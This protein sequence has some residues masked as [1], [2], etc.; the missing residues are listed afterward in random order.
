[1][2]FIG[3]SAPEM[4][5]ITPEAISAPANVIQYYT[6]NERANSENIIP[7]PFRKVW[8]FNFL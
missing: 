4:N 1:M 7:V 5:V 3:E 6:C 8:H 2:I